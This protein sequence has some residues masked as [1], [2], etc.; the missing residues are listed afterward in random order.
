[1]TSRAALAA[2][3]FAN[4]FMMTTPLRADLPRHPRLLLNAKGIEDLKSRI[5]TAPFAETW[6]AKVKRNVDTAL[7]Q[8]VELPPRGGNWTHWYICPKHA[9]KL[10]KGEQ[11][12]PW[13]WKHVCPV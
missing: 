3:L 12:G 1:M 9:V 7:D 4:C 8:K 2:L 10:Q 6:W 13:R 5:Q 11:I